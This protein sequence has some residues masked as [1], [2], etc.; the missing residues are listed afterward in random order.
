MQYQSDCNIFKTGSSAIA[1]FLLRLLTAFPV[2][3]KNMVIMNTLNEPKS[4]T[5]TEALGMGTAVKIAFYLHE[6]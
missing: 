5:F 2:E 6:C 1:S 3:V 4:I